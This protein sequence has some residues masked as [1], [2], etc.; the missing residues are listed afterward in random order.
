MKL[1]AMAAINLY[2]F[3][4]G[5]NFEPHAL[6]CGHAFDSCAAVCSIVGALNIVN[7]GMANPYGDGNVIVPSTP[8]DPDPTTKPVAHNNT[9]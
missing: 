4:S 9:L 7:L 8:I 5:L 3:E 2:M 6:P 1:F